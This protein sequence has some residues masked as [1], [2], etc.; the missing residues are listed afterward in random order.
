[1]K[2]RN[3]GLLLLG[4]IVSLLVGECT[5]APS[6][7]AEQTKELPVRT[8][9]SAPSE[10]PEATE[11]PTVT[12]APSQTP[13][14]TKRPIV[15]P[16]PTAQP[17]EYEL[18]NKGAK[19]YV[20]GQTGIRYHKIEGKKI[21]HIVSY[22]TDTV[23]LSM[24]HKSE[25]SVY[26]GGS[27][28]E[29]AKQYVTVSSSGTVICHRRG[30]G[31][32]LYTIIQ[33]K[34][35]M[36]G[37]IHYIY[38]YFKKKLTCTSGKK[39]KVL[40]K[41]SGQLKFD[42]SWKDLRFSVDNKKKAK[43][44]KKGR[45]T[46]VRHGVTYVNV[47]VKDSEKNQIRIRIEVKEG[48]WIVNKK[49]TV[50]DYRDMTNDLYQ[51]RRKYAGKMG[52]FSIGKSW[53]DRNIWCLR[54]G[55]PNASNRLVIDAAIHA[56]EWKNAQVVMRQAE[57][58]LRNYASYRQR[59]QSTCVYIIPMANPDGVT[60]AQYG[61]GAIRNKKLQK[62]CKKI[63]HFSIWKNNARGVNLNYNFPSGFSK[64]RK[65]KKPDYKSY[66]GK[67][68][69]SEKETKALMKFIN[70]IH[71]HAVLNIHS[72]GSVIYW[73]FNVGGSLHQRLYNLAAK[74]RSYNKYRMMPKG[75]STKASGGFGDWLVYG[76]G[77]PSITIE[78]GTVRCPLPHSQFSSIYK[79]NNKM[80]L[81]FMT[82][83]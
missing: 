69:G 41:H 32:K 83:Y 34:S 14:P 29:V 77:I 60:L 4:I 50:Y 66:L 59:F 72:M 33:A 36:T 67:K 5:T 15:T 64:K 51:I 11:M 75:G 81:W 80:F 63:G 20:G 22:T 8:V 28:K 30:K 49:D 38:I 56:R 27:K 65:S 19:Y 68:S 54:I 46:G 48:P 23:K 10:T 43:V 53:D 71:P 2:H 37:E 26:G 74:A 62:R 24:S 44:N 58:I 3:K 55:N 39:L 9:T 17:E 73:N 6:M 76:K 40:E 47:K 57:E 1:M 21:Y 35:V 82:K 61:A 18:T 52:V 45:V 78:T 13:E 70:Q 25:F 16:E 7:A 79:R 42:Y 31:E 12:P